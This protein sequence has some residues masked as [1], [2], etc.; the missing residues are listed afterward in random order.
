MADCDRIELDSMLP[1]HLLLPHLGSHLRGLLLQRDRVDAG[2]EL[3]LG[4]ADH[5]VHPCASEVD[6]I[7]DER[8]FELHH[9]AGAVAVEDAVRDPAQPFCT[10]IT[11]TLAPAPPAG[12]RSV[13]RSRSS[14]V[15]DRDRRTR[16]TSS[17]RT[18]ASGECAR[19]VRR[20]HYQQLAVARRRRKVPPRRHAEQLAFQA[21]VWRS[22]TSTSLPTLTRRTAR[23][24]P[25][26]SPFPRPAFADT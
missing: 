13:S 20:L 9:C 6:Q 23:P 4:H 2:L 24:S 16:R 10:Q 5:E 25:R 18:L 17:S 3:E 21:F 14:S 11:P 26:S 12:D 22:S 15:R 7:V 1:E 19:A 8:R